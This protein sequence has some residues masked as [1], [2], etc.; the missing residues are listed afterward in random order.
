MT[1]GKLALT[2]VGDEMH[3]G[4]YF[5]F[6]WYY[7][8]VGKDVPLDDLKLFP[9]LHFLSLH[10]SNNDDAALQVLGELNRIETLHLSGNKITSL[11]MLRGMNDLHWL[12]LAGKGITD[13]SPLE[14]KD[15]REFN[16]LNSHIESI[17]TLRNMQNLESVSFLDCSKLKD[18]SPVE[19]VPY[20]NVD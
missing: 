11:E 8:G 4:C 19:H 2:I 13:L 1:P 17:E 9:N 14:G 3:G 5:D 15:L 18:L 7:D 16:L 6:G 12:T 10:V 20:V